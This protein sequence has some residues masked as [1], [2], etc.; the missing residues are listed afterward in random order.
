M[1]QQKPNIP[2]N[3][4]NSYMWIFWGVLLIAI[5]T[6]GMFSGNG[7]SP[8]QSDWNTVAQMIQQNEVKQITI[9]NRET[10]EVQLTDQ[11]IEKYRKEQQFRTMPERGTAQLAFTI[12]S[13][14]AFRED[15]A[16]AEA[17]TQNAQ[18]VIVK[19]ESRTNTWLNIIGPLLPWV[20]LIGFWIFMFRG[21]R[22]SAGGA[23]G[24]M[25]VGK[26]R[27]QVFDKI[28]PTK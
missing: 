2:F 13:V 12:G 16:K 26:A 5:L 3:S 25:N 17:Q 14:D 28:T 27:A 10:A 15:L 24:I 20:L 8:V 9:V 23:G 6:W 11:A 18:P 21:A 22:N 7:G 4:K 1:A 19:Y